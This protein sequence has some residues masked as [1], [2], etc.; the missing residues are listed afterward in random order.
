[1]VE[2]FSGGVALR[3]PQ[4]IFYHLNIFEY[5]NNRALSG[6]AAQRFVESIAGE[7]M[8]ARD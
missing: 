4:D 3:D 8:R 7:F 6:V 1:M 2:F 5:F